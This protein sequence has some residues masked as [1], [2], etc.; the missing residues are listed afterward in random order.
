MLPTLNK[1]SIYE[2]NKPETTEHNTLTIPVP[3]PRYINHNI[4][5]YLSS[6]RN[7]ISIT[8]S[9]STSPNTPT[10][11]STYGIKKVVS[12]PHTPRS[13]LRKGQLKAK[14]K[15]VKSPLSVSYHRNPSLDFPEDF[16]GFNL[17]PVL[18]RSTTV[19]SPS[20]TD[21]LSLGISSDLIE[22]VI[23]PRASK[24]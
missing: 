6:L 7:T 17:T 5:V 8:P 4:K 21:S 20:S 24:N 13:S 18:P 23:N 9:V 11:R 14:L 2:L 15:K 10:R 3:N 16:G 12:P 22:D 1:S 19:S